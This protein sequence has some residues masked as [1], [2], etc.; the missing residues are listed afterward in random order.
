MTKEEESDYN[1]N[2][3]S[4]KKYHIGMIFIDIFTKYCQVAVVSSKK[5]D[6][7][8]AGLLEG[9]NKM[10]GIPQVI[11]T[12]DEGSFTTNEFKELLDEKGI[13]HIITRGHPAVAERTIR[14]I[15]NMINKRLEAGNQPDSKWID[16]LHQ[17]LFV[18]N[19]K[20]EHS[21]TK[22]TPIQAKE[23]KN[24]MKVKLNLELKRKSTRR[25]PDVQIG[26]KVKIYTK[27]SSLRKNMFQYGQKKLI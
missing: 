26:D 11:Y 14:T 9:L 20:M 4:K 16:I 19:Y 15:K 8:L 7:I 6:D 25:Y 24:H 5:T 3:D 21:A 1:N 18:H 10:Q 2:K 13:K 12:D 22:M 23:A 17:V 27:R